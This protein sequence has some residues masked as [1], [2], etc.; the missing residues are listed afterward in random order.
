MKTHLGSKIPKSK[1]VS[2][3]NLDLKT[4]AYETNSQYVEM[5]KGL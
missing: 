2:I 5:E 4:N 3:F 1:T